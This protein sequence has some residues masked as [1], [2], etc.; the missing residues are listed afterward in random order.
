MRTISQ[1]I[2]E[3]VGSIDR[4]GKEYGNF[5]AYSAKTGWYIRHLNW[6]EKT[7]RG[8]FLCHWFYYQT[9]R[10]YLSKYITNA[11]PVT[12]TDQKMCALR[13]K[14]LGRQL[15]VSSV[16]TTPPPTTHVPPPPPT[17]PTTPTPPSTTVVPLATTAAVTASKRQFEDTA[18]ALRGS[19]RGSEETI[20]YKTITKNCSSRKLT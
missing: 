13:D 17:T 9:K 15:P 12:T 19:S 2:Q 11:I 1:A 16:N 14:I 3:D 7:L 20:D 10:V 6:C 8:I 5:L 18:A 4:V